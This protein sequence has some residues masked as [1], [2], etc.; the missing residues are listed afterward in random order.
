MAKEIKTDRTFY[1]SMGNSEVSTRFGPFN[2]A[3]DA[4]A[5]ARRLGWNWVYVESRTVDEFDTVLDL[6]TRY[7]QPESFARDIFV[8]RNP[9]LPD[10]DEIR[11]KLVAARQFAPLTEGEEKFFASYEEQLS[12]PTTFACAECGE[13]IEPTDLYEVPI[14]HADGSKETIRFHANLA[15]CCALKWSSKRLDE[16]GR[17][18]KAILEM[19]E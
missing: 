2:T 1:A 6:K 16:A 7:Y 4:E 5:H 3:E 11:S 14:E 10:V 19:F 17:K 18:L 8:D 9:G 12:A 15:K 13:E